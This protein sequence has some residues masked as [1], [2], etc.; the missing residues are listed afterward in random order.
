MNNHSFVPHSKTHM[1]VCSCV[2]VVTMLLSANINILEMYCIN[3]S[4]MVKFRS[5][6]KKTLK[7]K[8]E[9]L[10][11]EVT[12]VTEVSEVIRYSD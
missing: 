11:Q 9:L 6:K 5:N 4:N 10:W 12:E 1:N 3:L 7:R 2:H 8:D